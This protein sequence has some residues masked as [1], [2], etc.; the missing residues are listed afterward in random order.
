MCKNFSIT[1]FSEALECK[2]R[3]KWIC[4]PYTYLVNCLVRHFAA[5]KSSNNKQLITQ[6]LFTR[7]IILNIF[8]V[9]YCSV[10][11]IKNHLQRIYNVRISTI[12]SRQNRSQNNEKSLSCTLISFFFKYPSL[13]WR[14]REKD[15][16]FS[17]LH[18]FYG[19]WESYLYFLISYCLPLCDFY[20]NFQSASIRSYII[21]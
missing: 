8:I 1:C 10:V 17:L 19:S 18:R 11:Y 9:V 4:F 15:I 5:F 7:K 14:R 3:Q 12:C 21:R 2:Q 13:H 6:L 16:L 20:S